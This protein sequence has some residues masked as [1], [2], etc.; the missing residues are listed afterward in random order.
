LAAGGEGAAAV[1]AGDPVSPWRCVIYPNIEIAQFRK[2]LSDAGYDEG[3]N[4]V[5][6][7]HWAEGR[8][9]RLPELAADLVRLGASVIVAA[10]APLA[11][12]EAKAATSMIPIVFVLGSDP[13]KLGLV[14]SLNRPG[15][16]MTGINFITDELG[17]KRVDLLHKLV[18]GATNIAYL[19][20]TRI[21]NEQRN[22]ILAA[23]Q[24]LGQQI[25]IVD[26]T[27]YSTFEAAFAA[28]LPNGI[29]ALVVG[30]APMLSNNRD[31]I[32]ALAA[33]HKIPAI[34]PDALYAFRGGLMSYSPYTRRLYEQAVSQYVAPILKGAKPADLPVQ[35]STKFELVIN[36]KAAKALGLD[37]P[38][39]LL[40][41]ADEVIE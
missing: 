32:V 23:A 14:A 18:P 13:V 17:S 5:I 2:A 21:F 35:Q 41:L 15:G 33:R 16:N 39:M 31:K 11:A 4:V 20:G 29:D 9:N 28:V 40:A 8:L 27:R 10:G 38:P 6:H 22:D 26:A 3:R 37:V 24:V 34:Y 25:I 19:S 36:L 30:V 1:D 7:Y 12:L